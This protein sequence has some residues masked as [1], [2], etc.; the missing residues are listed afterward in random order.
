MTRALPLALLAGMT[1]VNFLP[2]WIGPQSHIRY[3]MPLY[4]LITL[5]I[6]YFIWQA[7]EAR[8]RLAVRWLIAVIALKF[9]LG[10]WA[11]PVY[12]EKFRGNYAA[13]AADILEK[14]RGFP[15]YVTD[16]S[17]TGLSV[18]AHIDS[19]RYPDQPIKWPPDKWD[20]GYVLSYTA[21]PEL[22]QVGQRYPL[23]GN[24][25][26]LLCRGAACGPGNGK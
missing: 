20:N 6:A 3:I 11:F 25:L 19:L 4:P 14:T 7:G 12:Q 24:E 13:T 16:V 1:A 21:N 5:I 23:G 2:Y 8:V 10:L 18:S 26:Y 15:L 9:A 17:A 22:G